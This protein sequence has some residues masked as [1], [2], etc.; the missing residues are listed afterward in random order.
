MRIVPGA[1]PDVE[2]EK[3]MA[4]VRTVAPWNARVKVEKFKALNA[5]E[6]GTDGPACRAARDAMKAAFGAE[7]G[8]AGSG[9]SIPLLGALAKAAPGAEFILWGAEDMAMSRIHGANESVDPKEIANLI[10]AQAEFMREFAN[11]RHA[12]E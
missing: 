4:Y 1:D 8:E 2:I 6:A 10:V 12:T 11:G 5:F 7:V 9:G 3:L